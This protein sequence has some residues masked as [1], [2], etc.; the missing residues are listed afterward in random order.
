MFKETQKKDKK[1]RMV[2]TLPK[3]GHKMPEGVTSA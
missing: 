2:Q 3:H 1:D